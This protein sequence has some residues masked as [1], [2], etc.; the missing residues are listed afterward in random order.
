MLC[1][2]IRSLNDVRAF[3]SGTALRGQSLRGRS[4]MPCTLGLISLRYVHKSSSLYLSRLNEL[5][6][7]PPLDVTH[8]LPTRPCYLYSHDNSKSSCDMFCDMFCSMFCDMTAQ[9]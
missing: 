8:H 5:G 3:S 4:R 6:P 7:H 9:G 2:E 1:T